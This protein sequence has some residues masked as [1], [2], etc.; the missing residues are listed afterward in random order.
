MMA[1]MGSFIPLTRPS[2]IANGIRVA[3]NGTFYT[4]DTMV[5]SGNVPD[6][7][8]KFCQLQDSV[9][10]RHWECAHTQGSRSQ[11]PATVM[12]FFQTAPPCLTQHGWGCEPPEVR[13]FK[14]MLASIP[15]TVD[16]CVQLDSARSHIGRRSNGSAGMRCDFHFNCFQTSG[17][18]I[19]RG[20]RINACR[21]WAA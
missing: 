17:G 19:T 8:C 16:A 9:H 7:C 2:K 21:S 10:H 3:Q 11:I 14:Q 1:K 15:D 6:T 13:T 18:P 5:H 4:N 12:D 20:K